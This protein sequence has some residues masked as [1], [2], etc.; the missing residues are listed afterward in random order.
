[1]SNGEEGSSHESGMRDGKVGGMP[2]G[3]DI[4][5]YQ[6]S[7]DFSSAGVR[8]F[9][10]IASLPAGSAFEQ[11]S[12]SENQSQENIKHEESSAQTSDQKDLTENYFE[13]SEEMDGE[14][15]EIDSEPS[16]E[17]NSG[18]SEHDESSNSQIEG[19]S[20]WIP[21]GENR[22]EYLT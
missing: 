15:T 12:S 7:T 13:T 22:V 2:D 4:P 6:D 16:I 20:D 17:S 10:Q 5:Q 19:N 3:N 8:E 18:V 1:M 14:Q 21:E 9:N 11:Q